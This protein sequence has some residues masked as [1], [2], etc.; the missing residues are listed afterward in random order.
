MGIFR[1][2]S[3]LL[4]V[5]YL[6]NYILK[7]YK[8]RIADEKSKRDFENGILKS[9]GIDHE[10]FNE[11]IVTNHDNEN[12]VKQIFTAIAF[13]PEW[14]IDLIDPDNFIETDRYITIYQSKEQ[15]K[16]LKK[17]ITNLSFLIR[18]PN[19]GQNFRISDI[20][21]SCKN[22][23]DTIGSRISHIF[24][25]TRLE[26]YVSFS[27]VSLDESKTI[28]KMLKLDPKVYLRYADEHYDGLSNF[29]EAVNNQS[30]SEIDKDILK[31]YLSETLMKTYDEDS[32]TDIRV[33]EIEMFYRI[34]INARSINETGITTQAALETIKYLTGEFRIT[35]PKTSEVIEYRSLIFN[36]REEGDKELDLTKYFIVNEETRKIETETFLYNQDDDDN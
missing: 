15:I 23:A 16:R 6:G 30:L 35:N 32:I 31:N 13:S 22:A 24:F 1:I 7:R 28:T 3:S 33:H 19:C 12:L 26:G 2:G 17:T 18:I 14:D 20:I 36:A 27:Y 10:K 21:K 29:M 5:G 8:K 4:F 11:E 34:T 9:L 25:E